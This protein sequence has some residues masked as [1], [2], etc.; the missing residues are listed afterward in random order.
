MDG[1]ERRICMEAGMKK[2]RICR[3]FSGVFAAAFAAALW[4]AE[5][6]KRAHYVP[7]YDKVNLE[8]VLE[9]EKLSGD[10]YEMSFRQTGLAPAGVDQLYAEGR[11]DILPDLQEHFFKEVKVKCR[12]TLFLVRS[13][14]VDGAEALQTDFFPTLEEG[15][16]LVSFS[17]HIL[18][19]RSG[20]AGILVDREEELVLEAVCLGRDSA[21]CS[22][23]DW[24]KDPCIAVL[25]LRD[26]SLEERAEI[27]DYAREH[28]AGLPYRLDSFAVRGNR[29]ISESGLSG[30][31]CAHLI[32]WVYYQFGYDLDQGGDWI[33]TPGDLYRSELLEPVQVYGMEPGYGR[34]GPGSPID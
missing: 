2:K 11:Q 34:G 6:E 13:E 29:D 17:S 28:L 20:H 27:A 3:I 8:D 4:T 31:Q 5:T 33:V 21:L 19:W 24:K 12:H 26:V 18:G 7:D 14:Q 22:L 32:W 30:T 15:D 16:I 10:D 23:E 1:C 9:Q 25:R